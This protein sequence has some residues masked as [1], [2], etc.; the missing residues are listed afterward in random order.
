ML[1]C[2]LKAYHPQL[3]SN[4][5]I[6]KLM[7]SPSA[8]QPKVPGTWTCKT[9]AVM[10]LNNGLFWKVLKN[11]IFQKKKTCDTFPTE[12]GY[13]S[14][15][16]QYSRNTHT[17]PMSPSSPSFPLPWCPP[18]FQGGKITWWTTSDHPVHH[19]DIT[20]FSSFPFQSPAKKPK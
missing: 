5:D 10:E 3:L 17:Q 11:A 15:K 20:C 12:L 13:P 2:Q 14:T 1:Y 8:S 7:T 18:N 16:L 6:E 9:A 19:I 4:V